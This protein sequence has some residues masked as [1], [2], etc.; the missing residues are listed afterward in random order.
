VGFI[1]YQLYLSKIIF[2]KDSSLS[3]LRGKLSDVCSLLDSEKN[4]TAELT[5]KNNELIKKIT[6]LQ[7]NLATL[8]SMLAEESSL[9][10]AKDMENASLQDKIVDL[11][12]QLKNV[13]AALAEGQKTAEEQKQAIEQIKKENLKLS[14][15]SRMN[16]YRSEFFDRMQ[17]ILKGRE[18]FKVVG[19]RFALQA[20]LFFDS[21]SDVLSESGKDQVDKLA[22]VLRD[23]GKKI[24]PNIKWIVRIDGH[25][26]NRPIL[27]GKFASNWELSCA[28]AI[29]V[30]KHL[31]N[32]GIDPKN[33][34]AAGF[35]EHQ[36]IDPS[37]TEAAFA[38]N[39]RIEFK[40]DER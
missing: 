29:A 38:Q 17:V 36:P 32:S 1:S 37:K 12:Q 14:D 20:E 39:R 31:I 26:D 11:T 2:D 5:T 35:G 24:P 13:L 34:V 6:E 3:M 18:G 33:L 15:L 16:A 9:K 8:Q 23:I 27:G 40:L 7:E 30:V 25:T 22:S 28:R 10:Q 21:A 19:D 4:K